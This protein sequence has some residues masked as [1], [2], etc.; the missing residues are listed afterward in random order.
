MFKSM[1]ILLTEKSRRPANKPL[2]MAGLVKGSLTKIDEGSRVDLIATQNGGGSKP[3]HPIIIRADEQ[4]MV[5]VRI[6]SMMLSE[7][8][9]IA[10]LACSVVARHG[11]HRDVDMRKLLLV[12]D[13]I[14]PIH[15]IAR[16]IEP[17][18]EDRIVLS[19]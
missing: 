9:Q 18:N 6:V 4:R 11:Q 10:G 15:I 2:N 13:E 14:L 5:G 16:V 1:S 7:V 12:R 8:V 3:Q 19:V 17:A